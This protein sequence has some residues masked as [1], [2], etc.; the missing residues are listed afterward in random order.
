MQALQKPNLFQSKNYINGQWVLAE[1]GDTISVYNP[2]DHSLVGVVPDLC[3]SQ[4]QAAILAAKEALP[5]WKQKTAE[6]RSQ[7][8]IRFAELIEKNQADLAYLMTLEQ[9][10]PLAESLGE[11]AYGNSF[12][13]WFAEEAKRLYG[14]IIPSS[15]TQSRLMVIK[16]PIGVCA[17]IT[18]WNFPNAMILRKCA[19]ALAAGCTILIKP[20]SATPFSALALAVLAEEAGIPAGVFNILTGDSQKIGAAFCQSTHIKKLSFTGSTNVGKDLMA[21]SAPSLKKLSLELGGNAPFIVFS[22]AD[23]KAAVQGAM[24][25]KFRNSGQACTAAN[26]FYIHKE[27]YQDFVDLLVIEVKKL[28]VGSGFDPLT[29]IGPLINLAAVEKV[30]HLIED[31]LAKGA[32]LLCGGKPHPSSTLAY[33]PTILDNVSK[34]ALITQT[35]VFGPVIA[36]QA[37]HEDADLIEQANGT[38]YG[39]A[40]YFYSIDIRRIWKIAEA[41]D[42]GMIGINQGLISTAQAPFGGVKESGFGREGS[43]YGLEEFTQM[44]YLCLG[45]AE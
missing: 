32:R 20:S 31:A 45:I 9:G 4:I 34:D 5:N 29:T 19:P 23:L 41:L 1:N 39:L 12:N 33:T 28:K 3:D 8:L 44:R 6:E 42:Y 21:Q 24:Q 7:Y 25:A 26:R 14:D 2:F 10:K 22:D 37:F 17:A 16:E 36:L 27:I 11:I 40:A 15:S 43:K 30:T 13:I 38:L 18:P 35:E